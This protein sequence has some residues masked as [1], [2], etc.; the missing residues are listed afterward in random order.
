MKRF[1]L[2][3]LLGLS[4]C[5]LAQDSPSQPPASSQQQGEQRRGGMRAGGGVGGT[6]Q[7]I[8]GDTLTLTTRDGG[9]AT[10]KLTPDTRFMRDRQPAK[11]SDFKA[12]DRVMV[13]GESTGENS[14]TA[15]MVGSFTRQPGAAGGGN[16]GTMMERMREGMGK[17]F[18]AGEV[19]SI[20]GTKL[21]IH[22][23]D[24]KNYTAEV[25]ENTS[26]RKGREDIT[27][28]DVKVGDRVMGRGKPNADGVFVF[29]NLNVGGFMRGP[30][31][32]ESGQ[33]PAAPPKQ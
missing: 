23:M 18:L 28:P 13:I 20:D 19:K 2:V 32:P 30:R 22:G 33:Q 31:N 12:G 25:D 3:L 4:I 21:V 27:F 16:R 7:S 5:S 24:D 29:Q 10:V 11:L 6:I 8:N 17:E 1:L 15:N 14:W 26:F 9:T